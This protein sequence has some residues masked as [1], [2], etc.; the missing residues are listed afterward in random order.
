MTH[1]AVVSQRL[2]CQ[3]GM[4]VKRMPCQHTRL[5]AILAC[6]VY[7][8]NIV[9]AAFR[10]HLFHLRILLPCR[11]CLNHKG[12]FL[13]LLRSTR[14]HTFTYRV[15]HCPS[16]QCQS[17]VRQTHMYKYLNSTLRYEN[18]RLCTL[19]DLVCKNMNPCRAL[20][21][22]HKLKNNSMAVVRIS[23]YWHPSHDRQHTRVVG[24]SDQ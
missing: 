23:N 13:C 6:D 14:I 16:K 4:I 21:R 19:V 2:S 18:T 5:G 10:N 20:N 12:P 11:P 8:N 24:S 3:L 17:T 22:D 1:V 7:M 15:P 9:I